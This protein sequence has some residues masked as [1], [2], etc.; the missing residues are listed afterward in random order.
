MHPTGSSRFYAPGEAPS[1]VER[2]STIRR[3]V[4]HAA[5]SLVAGVAAALPTTSMGQGPIQQTGFGYGG[6]YGPTPYAYHGPAPGHYGFPPGGGLCPETVYELL[7]DDRFPS[8]DESCLTAFASAFQHAYLRLEYLNWD[9]D[10]PGRQIV[11]AP[12]ASG[13]ERGLFT[14]VDPVSQ[15][16]VGSAKLATLDSVGLHN[17]NGLRGTFG[18]PTRVGTFEAGI[19]VLE[20]SDAHIFRS[21][22]FDFTSFT[23]VF[24]AVTLLNNGAPSDTTMILFSEGLNVQLRS[25]FFSTEGN[26]IL[27]PLT[28]NQPLRIQPLFG[29]QYVR[30]WDNM[31]IF[32]TDIDPGDLTDPDDDRTLNHRIQSDAKNNVFAP[33]V[34]V[35]FEFVHEYF[36]L[37]VTPKFLLGF[38]RHR[39]EVFT[40]EIFS[41]TEGRITTRAEDSQFAPGLDLSVYGRVHLGRHL[42]LFVSYQLYYLDNISQA[43]DNIRYDSINASVPNIVLNPRQEGMFVDGITVG[44][45]FRFH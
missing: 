45:E 22:F 38:N 26:F 8:H 12:R 6:G 24:P 39:D 37:G 20:Q 32:G 1:A 28:P 31:D 21:R 23:T 29:F 18:L 15:V 16:I 30:F 4:V 11:G 34:G 43:E 41:A 44:G 17:N 36:S 10:D 9:L 19:S 2:H 27:N 42:S 35:R 13:G 14:A 5:W 25:E 33:Q 40:E 7:P 3:R